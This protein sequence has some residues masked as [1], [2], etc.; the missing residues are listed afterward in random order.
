MRL[1]HAVPEA[2]GAWLRVVER[3]EAP[4]IYTYWAA[5]SAV[6]AVLG[7]KV[8]ISYMAKDLFPNMY[9]LL[10]GD[11]ACKKST[12]I[13][14]ATEF[15][16][17]AGFERFAPDNTTK[18]SIVAEL[19][20]GRHNSRQRTER[21]Y[22]K[23]VSAPAPWKEI[24]AEFSRAAQ[25]DSLNA[26]LEQQIGLNSSQDGIEIVSPDSAME[27]MLNLDPDVDSIIETAN[28][29]TGDM[30]IWTDEFQQLFGRAP[31]E[32]LMLL[33]KLWDCPDEHHT[34]E[35]II[36]EP[37]ITI[38]SAINPNAFNKVFEARDLSQ[39]LLPRMIL[40]SAEPSGRSLSPFNMVKH[41]DQEDKVVNML[42]RASKMRGSMYLSQEASELYARIVQ[43]ITPDIV[44][45]DARFIHYSQR[46]HVQMIKMAMSLQAMH[47]TYEIT[48][49]TLLLANT[50]LC[51]TETGMG[52]ALGEYGMNKDTNSSQAIMSVL[53]CNPKGVSMAELLARVRNSVPDAVE[54]VSALAR[55]RTVNKVIT[56]G[57]GDKTKVFRV[58]QNFSKWA[59]MFGDVIEPSM[60]PEWAALLAGSE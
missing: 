1:H 59:P 52:N 16:K 14:Q 17:R 8:A 25:I 19:V 39:G 36:H 28:Y 22:V 50:I 49:D 9:T 15:L 4:Y 55:L 53:A 56:V 60:L 58:E 45:A 21:K 11:P 44:A 34:T 10:V 41:L 46:R 13:N 24:P 5:I 29:H 27:E 2:L 20:T 37:Y 51:F 42:V 26:Y 48:R 43:R 18:K 54:A 7:R 31:I 12:V 33:Q 6:S 35:G 57:E 40:V 30:A 38:F 47:G 23:R 32:A 3:H